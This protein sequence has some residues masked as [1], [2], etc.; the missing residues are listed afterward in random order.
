MYFYKAL[1]CGVV[2]LTCS[3]TMYIFQLGYRLKGAQYRKRDLYKTIKYRL[4]DITTNYNDY[5]R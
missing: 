3:N 4:S 1:K 5:A 2:L